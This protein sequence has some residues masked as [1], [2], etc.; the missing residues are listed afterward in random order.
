L[1]QPDAIA[2]ML[3]RVPEP[4]AMLESLFRVA[5]V[6]LQVFDARGH[7]VVANAALVSL[8]GAAPPQDYN[9]FCDAQAEAQGV[10]ALIRRA[11]AGEQITL[12]PTW[13]DPQ[14]NGHAEVPQG[15]RAAVE[16]TLFPLADALGRVPYVGLSYKDVTAEMEL[17]EARR[18]QAEVQRLELENRRMAEAA[19]A[20]SAVLAQVSHEL[21]TPLNA[22]LGFTELLQDGVVAPPSP[23]YPELLAHIAASGRQLLALIEDVLELALVES[24]KL[25]LRIERVALPVLIDEVCSAL[26]QARRL[27]DGGITVD[28]CCHLDSVVLDR[29]RLKQVLF[30]FLSFALAR[31]PAGERVTV[32]ARPVDGCSFRLEVEHA[33]PALSPEEGARLFDD[34]AERPWGQARA[35]GEHGLGLSLSR[36]LV[37]VQRGTAGFVH[38]AQGG[39]LYAELPRTLDDA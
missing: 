39:T 23:H 19:R 3:S 33:G 24:G 38:G 9:I 28:V 29:S 25:S 20:R 21:R 13:Y 34:F 6:A 17:R 12:P 1:T 16:L 36:R 26:R 15:R 10:T 11:F 2:E 14:A 22:I 37:E 18:A 4:L 32:R 5:P 8:F 31:S 35:P 30:N 27:A 7:C